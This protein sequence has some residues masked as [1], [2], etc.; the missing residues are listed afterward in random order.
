M[1]Y[2][3]ELPSDGLF[4]V[5]THF[6]STA[7]FKPFFYRPILTFEVIFFLVSAPFL[8]NVLNFSHD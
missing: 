8:L 2:T 4:L 1:N 3:Y 7:N 5:V 6:V